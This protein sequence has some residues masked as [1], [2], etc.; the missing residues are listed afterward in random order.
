MGENGLSVILIN[1]QSVNHNNYGYAENSSVNKF[2][3]LRQPIRKKN[4]KI[5]FR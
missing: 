1:N 5:F 4:I 3:V 2:V